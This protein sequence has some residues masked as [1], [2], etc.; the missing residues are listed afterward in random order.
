[1]VSPRARHR[2]RH[3]DHRGQEKGEAATS[4]REQAVAP[5][6][7]DTPVIPN[8]IQNVMPVN[9]EPAIDEKQLLSLPI[10]ELRKQ[11]NRTLNPKILLFKDAILEGQ[12]SSQ[13]MQ[14]SRGKTVGETPDDVASI[15]VNSAV[16]NS[17]L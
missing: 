15:L 9:T 4:P 14:A 12:L 1:M 8:T 7:G 17:A 3:K 13:E 10:E 6:K 2:G 5:A 16:D 11:G